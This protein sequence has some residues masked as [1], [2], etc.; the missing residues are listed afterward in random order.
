MNRQDTANKIISQENSEQK[1]MEIF[2]HFRSLKFA[3]RRFK[4]MKCLLSRITFNYTKKKRIT[5]K[6]YTNDIIVA[7]NIKSC[8]VE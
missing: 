3:I 2:G 4:Q 8:L 6:V 7:C 5:V 1:K